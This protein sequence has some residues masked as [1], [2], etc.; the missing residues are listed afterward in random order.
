MR[1]KELWQQVQAIDTAT[2]KTNGKQYKYLYR[3]MLDEDV[4][5]KAYKKLRKGKTKRAEI[6]AIDADLDN[7]V[8]SY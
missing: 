1:R 4:I 6:K 5:R 7:E 3:R 8:K 2:P